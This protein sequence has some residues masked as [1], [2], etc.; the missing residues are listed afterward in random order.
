MQKVSEEDLSRDGICMQ[1]SILVRLC[2]M[3][4]SISLWS[5][6]Y[7]S[8]YVNHPHY[9][10]FI[11]SILTC[12]SPLDYMGRILMLSD[13]EIDFLGNFH[14]PNLVILFRQISRNSLSLITVT[15]IKSIRFFCSPMNQ[16]IP[17]IRFKRNTGIFFLLKD[18]ST[19]KSYQVTK[20]KS[21]HAKWASIEFTKTWKSIPKSL[22]SYN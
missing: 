20:D 3:Y 7:A 19:M 16:I 18:G 22:D 1:T 12:E 6:W 11:L 8:F 4:G 10:L 15:Q 13:F 2:T 5:I 14:K 21:M 9:H 17:I